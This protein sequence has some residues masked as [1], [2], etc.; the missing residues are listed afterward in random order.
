VAGVFKKPS[1]RARGK[2]GKWTAWWVDERGRRRRRAAFTD[3]AAS[4]RMAQDLEMEARRVREGIV[5]PGERARRDAGLRPV[6]EHVEDYRLGLLARGDTPRHAAHAAG[7]VRRLL[8]DAGVGSVAD[9]AP[10][11]VQE[12]LGRLR[13]R[14][15]PRTANHA[16]GCLKAFA[17][18]LELNN[19]IKEVP[20]GLAAL[21]PFSEQVGRVRVRRALT[22]AELA[23]LLEAAETGG[24][25]VYVYG[26]TKSKLHKIPIAGAERGAI[27]R[28]AMGTGF[29]ANELRSLTPES[30]AL[31]GDEPTV[32][33][34]AA[35]SKN[36]RRAVQP[37]T[38]ELAA[39][40]RAFVE[41][42]PPGRPVLTVPDRTAQMLRVDL[43]RAGI[44]YKDA[45]GLVV[46]FHAI[47]HSYITH[48][49]ASGANPKVVQT[50][51]R[52]S[53][54]TLTL[55]RYT[56]LDDGDVRGA[57]EKGEGK[58]GG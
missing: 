16:L 14:R 18:W 55:D 33:V 42:R 2:A 51:A 43:K 31:D 22:V 47:R 30:F 17:R 4:L 41:G 32:T 36:G 57:L 26:P 3:R 46:D 29:R 8:A 10:D 11:R 21:R 56:H 39:G 13:A 15:S 54:I 34:E 23:R 49:I 53:T 1:D 40:L 28:L 24:D 20:R 7:A 48:L 12:A 50:L 45:A 35:Y 27:Y 6:V 37:I 5:D 25:V 52:H 44:P 9:I 58:G 19:R 38:R